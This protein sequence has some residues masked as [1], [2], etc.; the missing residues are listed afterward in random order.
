[1]AIFAPR[2][3]LG[4]IVRHGDGRGKCMTKRLTRLVT[5]RMDP[6]EYE[7]MVGEAGRVGLSFSDWCRGVLTLAVER[8]ED[9]RRVSR[10]AQ[11]DGRTRDGVPA[12]TGCGGPMHMAGHCPR[13][14]A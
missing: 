1:M 13:G 11:V 7:R 4:L 6:E 2:V 5:V 9:A 3:T 14:L 8:E 12:C 10:G